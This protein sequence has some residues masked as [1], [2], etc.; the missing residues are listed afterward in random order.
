MITLMA[1]YDTQE[2]MNTLQEMAKQGHKIYTLLNGQPVMLL[3]NNEARKMTNFDYSSFVQDFNTESMES[4][5]VIETLPDTQQTDD[6]YIE[7]QNRLDNHQ[8]KIDRIIAAISKPL[9]IN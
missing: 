8:E 5:M 3:G 6:K 7:I 9:F 4:Q 2:E 1:K